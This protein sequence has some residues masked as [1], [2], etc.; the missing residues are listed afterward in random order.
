MQEDQNQSIVDARVF[1]PI[2][3]STM[4]QT[5]IQGVVYWECDDVECG[6]IEPA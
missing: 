4:H 2:C 1:C 6:Y 5:T 3:G